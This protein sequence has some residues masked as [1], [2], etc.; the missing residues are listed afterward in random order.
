[1]TLGTAIHT[2]ILEPDKFEA[3]FHK[4][5]SD[6]RGNKWKDEM[7]LAE[8]EDKECLTAG[9]YDNALLIREQAATCSELQQALRGNV[10]IERSIYHEIDGMP[11]ILKKAIF[12]LLS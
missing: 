11:V 10:Y 1:M 4:G 2:A 7:S 6:R 5:P 8:S 9:D 3:Q 12:R